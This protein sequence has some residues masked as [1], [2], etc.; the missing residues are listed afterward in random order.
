ML[1]LVHIHHIL[2]C[3]G[4]WDR[5]CWKNCHRM[6][7][8]LYLLRMRIVLANCRVGN[9]VWGLQS[10]PFLCHHY[11]RKSEVAENQFKEIIYIIN[12]IF[13]CFNNLNTINLQILYLFSEHQIRLL[14]PTFVS[15]LHGGNLFKSSSSSFCF[16]LACSKRFS[17]S[18]IAAVG[19]PFSS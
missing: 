4:Y 18:S 19:L 15:E 13:P 1:L 3:W 2:S 17:N 5:H 8:D 9:T 6:K 7:E 12:S 16:C 14:T 10:N 11:D